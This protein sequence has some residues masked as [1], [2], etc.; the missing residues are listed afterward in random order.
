MNDKTNAV[1]D[2]P[3]IT[4]WPLY[5]YRVMVKLLSFFIFGLGNVVLAIAVF[6]AMSLLFHP[7]E[8]FNKYA[9]RFISASF[10][11]FFVNM[12]RLIGAIRMDVDDRESF[13]HL[14]SKIVVVNHPSLLD[15]VLILSLIPNAD[16]IVRGNLTRN[17]I[18]RWAVNRLYLLS[19]LDYNTLANNCIRSLDEGNCLVIFPQGTRTPRTGEIR[20]KKGAA[21]L[22]LSSGRNIVPVYIGGNDKL[23]LGKHDHWYDYNHTECYLYRIRMQDEIDPAKYADME[24]PRAV[25]RLN[26][27]IRQVFIDPPRK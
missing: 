8:R 17:I 11:I 14:S 10:R 15:M 9:R 3:P 22:S 16:V 24:T 1:P 25:R 26:N 6:P 7:R 19:D 27:E 4:N 12:M 18:L 13:R 23:G 21:R 5:I 20:L 2:A